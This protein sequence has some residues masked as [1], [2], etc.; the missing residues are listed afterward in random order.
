MSRWKSTLQ[1]FIFAV[2]DPQQRLQ[3]YSDCDLTYQSPFVNALQS[4]NSLTQLDLWLVRLKLD[5]NLAPPEFKLKNL[6]L[7]DVELS[8]AFELEWL[9]GK[10]D[11]GRGT[12]TKTLILQDLEFT[13]TP[14]SSS[15]LLSIFTPEKSPPFAPSLTELQLH[16]LHPLG[17]PT[18]SNVLSSLITL[19]TLLIGGAGVDLPLL[20]S[21]FP[22]LS[23]STSLQTPYPSRNIKHLTLNYLIHPSLRNAGYPPLLKL[24]SRSFHNTLFTHLLSPHAV[25]HLKTLAFQPNGRFPRTWSWTQRRDSMMPTW[26]LRPEHS[27]STSDESDAWEEFES[28]LRHVNRQRRKE[29]LQNGGQG[30]TGNITWLRN[31]SEIEYADVRSD[32]E[33]EE[34]QEEE[35]FDEDALFEPSSD[36]EQPMAVIRRDQDSDSDF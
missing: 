3:V 32:G 22:P 2:A 21:I 15:P 8:S 12:N 25:P 10:G 36:E 16:L 20:A 35:E 19:E 31:R 34:D 5:P 27:T 18:P 28:P 26:F 17:S 24:S 30:E 11:D 9:I 7:R 6:R 29:D 1:T 23:G 4:W 14:N 33:D 13:S